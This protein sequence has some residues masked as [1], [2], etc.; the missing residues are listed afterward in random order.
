MAHSN[1]IREFRLTDKG[2][3]LMDVYLGSGGVLT[4]TA[5]MTQEALDQSMLLNRQMELNRRRRNLERKR[6]LLQAN[7]DALQAEFAAEEEEVL[8][9][10]NVTEQ[11]DRMQLEAADRV[12]EQRGRDRRENGS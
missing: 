6:S 11:N 7:I 1:Q 9:M 3:E 8:T 10:L 2:I 12:A 4:G 5:R